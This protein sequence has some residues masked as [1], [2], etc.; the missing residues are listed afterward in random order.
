MFNRKKHHDTTTSDAHV[1]KGAGLA[2]GPALVLGT[3]LAIVGLVLFLHAGDTP[4]GGFPDADARGD[5]FLGFESNG[6]TAFFTTTA[7]V[8][9]L[10]AA[11]QHLLAKILGLVVG[12]ALAACVVLDL[13]NGPGVLGLAAANW[14]VD[15]LWGIAAVLL[16]LNVFAPR[17]KHEEPAGATHDRPHGQPVAATSGAGR[18]DDHDRRDHAP[19]GTERGAGTT[20][21]GVARRDPV[22]GGDHDAASNGP[23][24]SG[25]TGSGGASRID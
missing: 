4:T 10:F 15:L 14:A 13:V 17:I 19:I 24:S 23:S 11:A 1:V 20:G 25:G 8:I 5:T 22:G 2:R 6:W 3:I 18:A 16:L 9:L 12:L 21:D 7:G